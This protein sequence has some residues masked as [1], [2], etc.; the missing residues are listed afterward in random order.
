[1]KRVDVR[2]IERR[3]FLSGSLAATAAMI[4]PSRLFGEEAPSRTLQVGIIGLGDRYRAHTADFSRIPG[5]RV[6]AVCDVW[7]ERQKEAK[8]RVDAVN[9]DT[10]C[11]TY[12][13]YREMIADPEVDIVAVAAPD[14]WHALIAIEAARHGKHIY[15]EKPF[16][17]SVEEGRAIIRAVRRHGVMLQHGTQQRSTSSFQRATWLARSGHLG[18]V[19]RVHAISPPGPV[20][21][22]ATPSP[23]PEG[24]DF[25][26]FTGPAPTI[27]FYHDLLHKQEGGYTPG[28]Y[29]NQLFGGGWVTAWGSHHVDSAQFALGKDNEAPVRVE[30]MG[31]YPTTGA[32]DTAHTWH[33][34]F[35][36]A[37][38][39]KL[40][41]STADRPEAPKTDAN[42]LVIG[43]EG[44][45]A[46]T[47]GK[48][49]S[50][51]S[52]LVERSWPRTDPELQLMDEGG[53]AAHF[54]NF[55]DAIREGRR[56]NGAMDPG[57][58]ST[59]LCHLT[60][61]GIELQRPLSWDG[62][63]ERFA[64]DPVADRL[65]GRPMRPPW[66]LS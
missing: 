15:L 50:N 60:G 11:R 7:K 14:H 46:A 16:A 21:G 10:D 53:Q 33:A 24:F 1:M 26:F 55:I 44:W 28:W 8:S 19:H 49:W 3:R 31:D 18:T 34:E 61:I 42:I 47:R 4:L 64:G 17:Y 39:K 54:R 9:Q 25:D 38:G 65:L 35:E 43:D 58:L 13:D 52:S 57:H 23:I 40:L 51:P 37:D 59:T 48:V 41:Y 56:Q 2:E 36:Y 29:F 45:V 6:V 30:A 66:T 22:D 62:R 27:R 20:G 32:F 5:V 12:D 63:R